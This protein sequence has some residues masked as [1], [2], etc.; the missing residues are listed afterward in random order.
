VKSSDAYDVKDVHLYNPPTTIHFL[1]RCLSPFFPFSLVMRMMMVMLMTIVSMSLP[2]LKLSV[3]NSNTFLLFSLF[4]VSICVCKSEKLYRRKKERS[5]KYILIGN[6]SSFPIFA[7]RV[8]SRSYTT[9]FSYY[10]AD[11][12]FYVRTY[13]RFQ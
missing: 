5:Q 11:Y 7:A 12:A 13:S 9:L 10:Y 8:Y 1:Q 2:Q 3:S 6:P 4:V